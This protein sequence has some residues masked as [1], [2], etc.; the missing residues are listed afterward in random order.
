MKK[1][2]IIFSLV[3]FM[4]SCT[5]TMSQIPPQYI[6]VNASCGAAL[7]DYLPMFTF[8][9]NCEIDTV[10]QSP[11]R[12][13]WLTVPTTT[14]LIRAIDNFNN[15]TDLMFTVTLVDTIAPTITLLDSTLIGAVYDQ[16]GTLYN[17]ADRMLA[18]QEW[19]FD[20]N[21]PWDDLQIQYTDSI[22]NI[23]TI[24]GI[25][26]E[27]VP[28]NLYMNRTMITWT[29]AGHAFTGDGM[30]IYTFAQPG[31]TLIIR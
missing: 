11:T 16:V 24:T 6:Y 15:H 3:M 9:D 2:A 23:Q 20:A 18:R 19:W 10:W 31:D 30:R 29:A 25:P 7:P 4:A 12:G 21:F 28:S 13:T 1:L 27:L 17:M 26:E 5:C 14:V 22:G 8:T